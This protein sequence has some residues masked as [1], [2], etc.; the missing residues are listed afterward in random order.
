MTFF[1]FCVRFFYTCMLLQFIWWGIRYTHTHKYLSQYKAHEDGIAKKK[2]RTKT[3]TN[4]KVSVWRPN[5]HTHITQTQRKKS[6]KEKRIL[7]SAEAFQESTYQININWFFMFHSKYTPRRYVN[8]KK[9]K[10][11]EYNADKF[12]PTL[13][14][15]LMQCND[16]Q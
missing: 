4:R 3:C 8:K 11:N 15:I 14:N 6:D 16:W 13:E 5:E 10:K 12:N 2:R 1:T 7:D 9:K